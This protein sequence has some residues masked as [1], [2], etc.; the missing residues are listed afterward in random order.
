MFTGLVQALGEVVSD[1]AVPAGRRLVVEARL[2]GHRP[3]LGDSIAVNGCCLT[4]AGIGTEGSFRFDVV[5]ETLAKTTLGGLGPGSLVNLE[6]AATPSTLMGGHMVQG[7]VD[8]V[9][10]VLSVEQETEWRVRIG[11]PL[12]LIEYI[13]PKGSVCVEGVSLTVAGLSPSDSW[14]EVALIPTTLEKTTLGRLRPGSLCNI[15]TDMMAKTI[16]H[17]MK[18]FGGSGNSGRG[19]KD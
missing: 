1:Q 19:T 14:F 8:G 17:W 15:E 13:V 11:V 10:Q 3:A 18:H 16:V 6:H 5:P 7:H 9:A 2:W 4:V 12:A